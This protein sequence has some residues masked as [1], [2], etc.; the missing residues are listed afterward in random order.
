MKRVV[1]KKLKLKNFLSIGDEWIELDIKSGL[2][3]I[4]GFNH[5]KNSTNGVGK[6]AL[7]T[8][9]FFFALYGHTLRKLNKDE[10]A[11]NVTGGACK[12][13]ITF[14]VF[15]D[16]KRDEYVLMRQFTNPKMQLLKN[17]DDITQN[18]RETDNAIEDIIN[19]SAD[20]F[21]FAVVMTLNDSVG[22]MNQ[23]KG[24]R[25]K[26]V[27][28]ILR[29]GVFAEMSKLHTK[30]V[31]ETRKDYEVSNSRLSDARRN[32][33]Q[34][35]EQ[36]RKQTTR[37]LEKIQE[38][39]QRLLSNNDE[40]NRLEQVIKNI[41]IPDLEKIQSNKDLIVNKQKELRE[42]KE[43][44]ISNAAS[45]K[46]QIQQLKD[47]IAHIKSHGPSCVM[48]ERPFTEDDQKA[49]HDEIAKLSISVEELIAKHAKWAE[50]K[51]TIEDRITKCQDAINEYTEKIRFADSKNN[52]KNS[53]TSRVAQLKEWNSTIQ[54]DL[55][56]V[57]VDDENFTVLINNVCNNIVELQ[58][59]VA[60]ESER[61][62]ILEIVKFLL[63]EEGIK[64][65][66]VKKILKLLNSRLAHYLKKLNA[67][68][69]CSFNDIFDETIINE[70]GKECSYE[71]FSGGERKRIDLA[72]LFTFQDLRRLQSDTTINISVYDELIDSAL[73]SEGVEC[74]LSLLKDRSQK[75]NEAMFII[76]HRK[77]NA[78]LM[79]D[80]NLMF[81]EKKGGI[82]TLKAIESATM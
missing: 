24:D 28:S 18:I 36:T 69:S 57:S 40:I 4:T 71:A 33:F 34:Y 56:H 77:E 53:I 12:S 27:E 66:I 10:I 52:E 64:K 68:C 16:I 61:L 11:N 26:F 20:V 5:D 51:I 38:L 2:T 65:F 1:L 59:Q 62:E 8:D 6:S 74:V 82:T 35:E 17:G 43:I 7:F 49:D 45:I 29:L 9:S 41:I 44:I 30:I 50:S 70:K 76:T 67:P 39:Q 72:M 37:R 55:N 63:S 48:C 13:I 23:K 79:N 46:L 78:I 54:A 58:K 47:R 80:A 19:A 3:F 25:R 22:F 14:D 15:D 42:G 60:T 73:G 21:K 75:Y 81:L 32:L 31:M